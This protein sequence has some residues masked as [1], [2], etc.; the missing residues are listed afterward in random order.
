[1]STPAGATSLGRYLYLFKSKTNS[2]DCI[3]SAHGGYISDTRA[4]R[5]PAGIEL[6]FFSVH[7]SCVLDPRIQTFQKNQALAQPVEVFT[8]GQLCNNYLLTKYQGSHNQMDE[9]YQKVADGVAQQDLIRR[10]F[11]TKMFAAASTTTGNA[12]KL[13]S[14]LNNLSR[15]HGGSVLTVRNRVD[16]V[17]GIPLEDALKSA[18]KELRSLRVFHCLF[19][20]SNMLGKDK[21]AAMDVSIA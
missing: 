19:C 21:H 1:M 3:I 8:G 11:G 15:N 18:M 7:S 5:V 16:V 9:T 6:R 12:D 4:F 14:V 2:T 17:F 10:G 20:R 13:E